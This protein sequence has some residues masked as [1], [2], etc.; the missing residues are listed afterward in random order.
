[1]IKSWMVIAAVTLL[2]ALASNLVTPD[3]IR[4][5]RH[6]QRPKWLTFE[7]A[8]PIIWTIIFICGGWS[9][10]IVWEA[11]PG[12]VKTWWLMG[13]YLLVEVTIIA[14]NPVM[15]RLRSLKV[16]TIIGALGSILG[17]ILAIIVWP[18]SIWATIL[19]IPY[20]IWSP[21]GTYTTGE[22]MKLNP[23]DR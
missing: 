11:D 15:L 19:L 20:V 6:L 9:A 5:F 12:S 4:W 1:M 23:S 22:M 10:Y 16:G 8:I 14:Y 7:A 2:V 21:I 17:L 13:L 18:I 3:D